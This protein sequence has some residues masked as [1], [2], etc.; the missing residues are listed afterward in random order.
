VEEEKKKSEPK[1]IEEKVEVETEEHT[2]DL[3]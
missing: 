3:F 1:T 2:E